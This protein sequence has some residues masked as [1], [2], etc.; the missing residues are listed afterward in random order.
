[1]RLR[2]FFAPALIAAALASAAS[3]QEVSPNQL[4]E[5]GDVDFITLSEATNTDPHSIAPGTIIQRFTQAGECRD[6]PERYQACSI[7]GLE[8]VQLSRTTFEMI[9]RTPGTLPS[10]GDSIG[11]P[12]VSGGDVGRPV[13]I[14]SVRIQ[15]GAG[16]PT[17]PVQQQDGASNNCEHVLIVTQCDAG[18]G[19]RSYRIGGLNMREH[20]NGSVTIPF[21]ESGF[22]FGYLETDKESAVGL[23]WAPFTP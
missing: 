18:G 15:G 2:S 6:I 20:R 22:G 17:R 21:G 7:N 13:D 9:R 10:G 19:E 1:M 11:Q 12:A 4:T 8:L 3:A 23:R 5:H 14:F 16:E